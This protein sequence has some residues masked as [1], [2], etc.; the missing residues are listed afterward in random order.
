MEPSGAEVAQA[1]V[2]EA[3]RELE[4]ALA[5]IRHC[6]DQLTDEQIWWRPSESMN[7]IANLILH[8]CGNVRQW[9]VAGLGHAP[10]VRNRPEEFSDRSQ[11]PRAELLSLLEGT[12][13]EAQ[14]VL[15]ELTAAELLRVRRIQGFE[16]SGVGAIFDAVPHFRG[17]V[18]EIVHLTRMLRGDDY[19]FAWVPVTREADKVTR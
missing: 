2:A 11:R 17:H 4:K 16:V 1:L 8:L 19:R 6:L 3:G 7:S 5:R 10:D 9:I 15:A 14:R 13:S 12:V 18:Q